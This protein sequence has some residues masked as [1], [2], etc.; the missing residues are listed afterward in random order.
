[1]AKKDKWIEK[2][3]KLLARPRK[4]RLVTYIDLQN[5]KFMEK[6]PKA[7]IGMQIPDPE[8]LFWKTGLRRK[9]TL[10][11]QHAQIAAQF[12]RDLGEEMELGQED[13]L[14]D[15]DYDDAPELSAFEA[16]NAV[17]DGIPEQLQ[18]QEEVAAG[19]PQKAEAETSS[20]DVSEN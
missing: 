17:Y 14:A 15:E 11:E 9:P 13:S 6:Y 1:M 12:R 10:Q 5:P 19:E 8:P 4:A 3:K 2:D 20:S 7:Q 16:A 18:Q